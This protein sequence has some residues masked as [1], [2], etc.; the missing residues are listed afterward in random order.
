MQ[1]GLVI[2]VALL[3]VAVVAW[4]LVMRRRSG[5]PAT[6][7]DG[8]ARSPD[9]AAALNDVYDA[10][11]ILQTEHDL[12]RVSDGDYREQLDQ[13]RRQAALILREMDDAKESDRCS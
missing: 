12:G 13:Y 7:T 3:V 8:D 1:L 10:I 6:D 2:A 4:P 11:R 9:A 5:P